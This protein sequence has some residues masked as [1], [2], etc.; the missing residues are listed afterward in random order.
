MNSELRDG[1][2]RPIES[3]I[4][5]D[6]RRAAETRVVW[7]FG[8]LLDNVTAEY[9]IARH[10]LVA[11]LSTLDAA[12]RE[13]ESLVDDRSEAVGY[14]NTPGRV[15]RMPH[16][17]WD[18]LEEVEDLSDDEMRAAR[19]VHRRMAVALAG[20]EPDPGA[21]FFVFAVESGY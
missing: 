4:G 5:D 7:Y 2:E 19:A 13:H 12:A 21:P 10:R 20:A 3:T 15:V 8:D 16:Q 14:Q 9:P 11:V 18:V 1:D 6:D 17:L